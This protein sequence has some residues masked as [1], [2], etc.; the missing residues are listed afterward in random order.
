MRL[1]RIQAL[2]QV[3]YGFRIIV[4]R[5]GPDFPASLNDWCP[6]S[7]FCE[8]DGNAINVSNGYETC[9]RSCS[10]EYDCG[11]KRN[12]CLYEDDHFRIEEKGETSCVAPVNIIN[13]SRIPIGRYFM[14]DK[15]PGAMDTCRSIKAAA[16]GNLYPHFSYNTGFIYYNQYCARCHNE[17]NVVSWDL[18]VNCPPFDNEQPSQGSYSHELE[19]VLAGRNSPCTLSFRVPEDIDLSSEFC[20]LKVIKECRPLDH[21]NKTDTFLELE[22]QCQQFNATFSP[23]SYQS[24]TV[25]RN[26][27]CFL[28]NKDQSYQ[29]T[30]IDHVCLS[31]TYDGL[32]RVQP[33]NLIIL[34]GS[35]YTDYSVTQKKVD[36]MVCHQIM[37]VRD[38][39]VSLF[40]FLKKAFSQIL[41][42]NEVCH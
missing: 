35:F 13:P 11:R 12:C 5:K 36:E 33:G 24:Q 7:S 14:I 19:E 28:C 38:K 26:V 1:Q 27:Y 20:S 30:N 9:C 29:T 6:Y 18:A 25:F 37:K 21:S 16:W 32:Y 17:S 40:F 4:S 22:A 31:N 42:C 15:C 2:L 41:A 34:L 10:C 39:R 8:H 23:S 3:I